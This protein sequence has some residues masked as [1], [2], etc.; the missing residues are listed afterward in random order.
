MNPI[1]DEEFLTVAEAAK[2]LKV[3]QSTIWRRINQGGLPAYRVGERR[4][5]L[6]ARELARLITPARQGREEGEPMGQGERLLLGPL[7]GEEQ[8][9]VLAAVEAARRLQALMLSRRSGK[10]FPSSAAI[11][12]RLREE[13]TRDLL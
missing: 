6:K 7:T 3:S 5:R 10:P 8:A 13:R 11:I 1:V 2:L 9:K 4:I 12:N